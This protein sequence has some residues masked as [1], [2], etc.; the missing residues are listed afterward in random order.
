MPLLLFVAGCLDEPPK[1]R[2]DHFKTSPTACGHKKKDSTSCRFR[3]RMTRLTGEG[4][5]RV[6][7]NP[8]N[9][10]GDIMSRR[11]SSVWNKLSRRFFRPRPSPRSPIRRTV[12]PKLETMEDRLVPTSSADFVALR[13]ALQG[14]LNT[15]DG[16]LTGVVD[17]ATAKLPIINQSL[18]DLTGT[19]AAIT[20]FS[21]QVHGVLDFLST[22]NLQNI[23]EQFVADHLD[24]A[25]GSQ[26]AGVETAPSEVHFAQSAGDPLIDIKLHLGK[27]LSSPTFNLNLGLNSLPFKFSA[28]LSFQFN[29]GFHIMD[30]DGVTDTL[31]FGITNG[32]G[33][34]NSPVF[35]VKPFQLVLSADATIND[36]NTQVD[37]QGNPILLSADV[38]FVHVSVNKNP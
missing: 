30:A 18:A 14:Y 5:K 8:S 37:N 19:D 4:K 9:P 2:S 10:V 28:N 11:T 20:S 1:V 38:G 34:N 24:Q 7:P 26:G 12:R 21:T 31:E 6:P 35:F 17:A 13:N 16:I 22:G 27:V 32:N 15:A 23:A 33:N 25:L 36:P 3:D 29:V